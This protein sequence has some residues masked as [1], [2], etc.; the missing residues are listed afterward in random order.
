MEC[1]T[2]RLNS[3]ASQKRPEKLC[4]PPEK[5]KKKKKEFQKSSS[6]HQFVFF[7]PILACTSDIYI[8]VLHF[9][10][11]ELTIY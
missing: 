5:M 4:L 9:L 11:V 6:V 1:S 10:C 8:I 3:E 7:F 2:A